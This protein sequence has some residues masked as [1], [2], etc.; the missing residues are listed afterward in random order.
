TQGKQ[1]MLLSRLG[2]GAIFGEEGIFCENKNSDFTVTVISNKTKICSIRCSTFSFRFPR[3]AQDA[4]KERYSHKLMKYL[5]TFKN[6]LLTRHADLTPISEEP[7]GPNART[8]W[9]ERLTIA[10][11]KPE[12][13]MKRRDKI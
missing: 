8:L 4:L 12:I 2:K 9:I 7:I 13:S 1:K 11:L 10:D 6:A 5:T 3:E